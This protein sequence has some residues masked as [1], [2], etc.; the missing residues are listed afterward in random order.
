MKEFWIKFKETLGEKIFSMK[1]PASDFAFP[2]EEHSKDMNK[3]IA[4]K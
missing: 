1:V 4:K 2:N 3:Y